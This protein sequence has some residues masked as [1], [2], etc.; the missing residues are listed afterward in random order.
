MPGGCADCSP[1]GIAR[2]QTWVSRAHGIGARQNCL[3]RHRFHTA[4][5]PASDPGPSAE[6]PRWGVERTRLVHRTGFTWHR[7]QS[8]IGNATL[9]WQTPQDSPAEIPIIEVFFVPLF[10]LG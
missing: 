9:V 3:A 10:V 7:S 5:K 8:A 6:W 4:R 1:L 2:G